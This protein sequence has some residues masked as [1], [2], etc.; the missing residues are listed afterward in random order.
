MSEE[1]KDDKK[2]DKKK[3]LVCVL[4][5][6]VIIAIIAVVVTMFTGGSTVSD[7]QSFKVPDGFQMLD[8][9][10]NLVSYSDGMGN[11]ISI[12]KVTNESKDLKEWFTNSSD[13]TVTAA[14]EASTKNI[15][16]ILSTTELSDISY[17]ELV[18]VEGQKYII[19][20]SGNWKIDENQNILAVTSQLED[21]LNTFNNDNGVT[22][23]AV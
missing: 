9:E 1:T 16:K 10:T 13:Y 20:F 15:Y 18:E 12:K 22:A 7:I 11:V 4:G 8:N 19:N 5:I 2:F 14:T 6:L 21:L 3:A 23:L 17:T